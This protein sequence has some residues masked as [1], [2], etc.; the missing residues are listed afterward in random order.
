MDILIKNLGLPIWFL[1]E[2]EV[3]VV[4]SVEG[5]NVT[6]PETVVSP[7]KSSSYSEYLEVLNHRVI[8]P[9]IN[10]QQ[11]SRRV[12]AYGLLRSLTWAN[13]YRRYGG[14][15]FKLLTGEYQIFEKL[16]DTTSYIQVSGPSLASYVLYGGPNHCIPSRASS[17]QH[18]GTQATT[19]PQLPPLLAGSQA[20]PR[21]APTRHAKQSRVAQLSRRQLQFSVGRGNK[22]LMKVEVGSHMLACQ[23]CPKISP[24]RLFGGMSYARWY[25]GIFGCRPTPADTCHPLKLVH[26]NLRDLAFNPLIE[27]YTTVRP[28]SDEDNIFAHAVPHWKV[29]Q[30]MKRILSKLQVSNLMFGHQIR[31][32]IRKTDWHHLSQRVIASLTSNLYTSFTLS[33][34]TRDIKL[35]GCDWLKSVANG[36]NRQR[37]MAAFIFWLVKMLSY[38]LKYCFYVTES[39]EL[40]K[41]PLFFLRHYWNSKVQDTFQGYL[42]SNMFVP[43]LIIQPT[44]HRLRF[45]AGC[46]KLRPIISR[47]K[48]GFS[49]TQRYL[50]MDVLACLKHIRSHPRT[51]LAACTDIIKHLR[52]FVTCQS[53]GRYYFVKADITR[54][55]DSIDRKQLLDILRSRIDEMDVERFVCWRLG[56]MV[57]G[58]ELPTLT[59]I[60]HVDTDFHSQSSSTASLVP[61]A[62]KD[63]L[64]QKGISSALFV[65]QAKQELT[66]QHILEVVEEHL[67]SLLIDVELQGVTSRYKM[68][69]GIPQGSILSSVLCD[70]YYGAME[71]AYLSPELQGDDSL[72]LRHVDDYLLLTRSEPSAQQFLTTLL[73]REVQ[74]DFSCLVKKEKTC[75]NLRHSIDGVQC[76]YERNIQWCQYVI[77]LHRCCVTLPQYSIKDIRNGIS[78]KGSAK[79]VAH[80]QALLL[81][82]VSVFANPIYLD[83]VIND[84]DTVLANISQ[85]FHSCAVKFC[86]LQSHLLSGWGV[87][88]NLKLWL[89]IIYK[90]SRK[91]YKIVCNHS[92]RAGD[93]LRLRQHTVHRLC[94]EQFALQCGSWINLRA[95]TK[96][97]MCHVCSLQ[98]NAD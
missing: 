63:Y 65:T 45:L 33:Q 3:V 97:M 20:T 31:S 29:C 18:N 66:P 36:G 71:W 12:L 95:L 50:L 89:D 43:A 25:H 47:I 64:R 67:D 92:K 59:Y 8:E 2:H 88:R 30:L 28:D 55:Y 1:D 13:L 38:I 14:Y 21:S 35:S 26:R 60:D 52:R 51:G 53:S 49:C 73:S 58:H 39:R 72:L 78:F 93:V 74:Q 10:H 96:L 94:L 76:W 57:S 22:D 56:V 27:A 24:D 6:L 15:L 83:Y 5:K 19:Q 32:D 46:N 42:K 85:I 75:T 87:T 68:A 17:T 90:I 91:L 23:P 11:T 48:K 9:Y 41:R 54:C 79:P 69:R 70:I 77:D 34:L 80:I 82:H 86:Y 98:K 62:C 40:K 84:S 37:T 7:I 61:N 44:T 16:L 81:K 4:C